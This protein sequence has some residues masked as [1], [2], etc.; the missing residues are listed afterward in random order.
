MTLDEIKKAAAET[1]ARAIRLA[2]QY[3]DRARRRGATEADRI[4]GQ[5]AALQIEIA[6][7]RANLVD[8]DQVKRDLEELAAWGDEQT[9]ALQKL[10]DQEL[11]AGRSDFSTGPVKEAQDK[12]LVELEARQAR[13]ASQFAGH[14]LN[15]WLAACDELSTLDRPMGQLAV[16]SDSKH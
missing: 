12:M 9:L 7:K 8:A 11:E 3:A 4:R 6:E 10:S 16:A 13:K 15:A 5:V 14:V 1:K 2:K